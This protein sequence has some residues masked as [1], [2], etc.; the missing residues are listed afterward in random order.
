[1]Y[2]HIGREPAIK[3]H[4]HSLLGYGNGSGPNY[5]LTQSMNAGIGSTGTHNF[6]RTEQLI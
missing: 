3:H 2:D 1:M 5:N 4:S 6:A